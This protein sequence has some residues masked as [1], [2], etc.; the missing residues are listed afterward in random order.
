MNCL[1]NILF[2]KK[3]R[4]IKINFIYYSILNFSSNRTNTFKYKAVGIPLLEIELLSQFGWD[5][6]VI[7]PIMNEYKQTIHRINDKLKYIIG[8]DEL[9]DHIRHQYFWE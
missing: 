7:E 4:P 1:I 6:F 5:G 3:I 8:V 9:L 2:P